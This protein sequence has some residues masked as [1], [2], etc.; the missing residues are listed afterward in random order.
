MKL[1]EN[2]SK[3]ILDA[4]KGHAEQVASMEP[5]RLVDGSCGESQMDFVAMT[6]RVAVLEELVWG[7]TSELDRT[8]ESRKRARSIDYARNPTGS[9]V[10]SSFCFLCKRPKSCENW[11]LRKGRPSGSVCA[12]SVRKQRLWIIKWEKLTKS[13]KILSR[14][15]SLCFLSWRMWKHVRDGKRWPWKCTMEK[16]SRSNVCIYININIYIQ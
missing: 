7:L 6:E 5:H 4:L 12:K 1:D 16:S 9:E 10:G 3:R 13:N 11:Y 2:D 15:V 8:A 14:C